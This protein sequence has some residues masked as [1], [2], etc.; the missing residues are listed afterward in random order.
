[1]P[2]PKVKIRNPLRLSLDASL[3]IRN[4]DTNLLRA[5]NDIDALSC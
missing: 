3:A 5:G 4:L 1:M 2:R